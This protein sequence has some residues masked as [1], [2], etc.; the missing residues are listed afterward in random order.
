MPKICEQKRCRT[1]T[2]EPGDRWCRTHGLLE[3]RRIKRANPAY[4]QPLKFR[5]IDGPVK[6]VGPLVPAGG[7]R[8]GGRADGDQ[9]I[10][11]LLRGLLTEPAGRVSGR[12]CHEGRVLTNAEI[13]ARRLLDR[14]LR[15]DEKVQNLVIDRVEGKAGRAA[16]PKQGDDALL[17][18]LADMDVGEI[19]DL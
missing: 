7:G 1:P 13:L 2:Q 19:N 4:F 10:A 11:A 6:A 9:S 16:D 3:L 17:A 12:V 15:N 14:A 18:D 8:S 5:S